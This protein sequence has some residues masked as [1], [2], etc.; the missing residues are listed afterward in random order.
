MPRYEETWKSTWDYQV[1]FS[2][3]FAILYLSR[4]R[5]ISSP[6]KESW[7][8]QIFHRRRERK[9]PS[10]S[11]GERNRTNWKKIRK[12]IER[13]I[14]KSP[15]ILKN[16][17]K[18]FQVFNIKKKTIWNLLDKKASKESFQVIKWL[19]KRKWQ[20]FQVF[21]VNSK[22]RELLKWSR[23]MSQ[24]RNPQKFQTFS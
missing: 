4:K 19:V 22:K 7:K 21:Y 14:E 10:L 8:F 23:V 3:I 24:K 12:T 20:K 17:F 9:I 1:S 18:E 6:R 11:S 15:N 16:L 13:H 5:K 2:R